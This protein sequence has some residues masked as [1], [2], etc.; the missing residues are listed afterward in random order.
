MQRSE[1]RVTC[2]ATNVEAVWAS[3]AQIGG[4]SLHEMQSVMA[5]R[6]LPPDEEDA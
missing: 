1:K 5:L 3:F 6:E 2:D 4:F